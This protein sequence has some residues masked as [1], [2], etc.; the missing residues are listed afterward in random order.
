MEI[1][2]TYLVGYLWQLFLSAR[3]AYY[4][5]ANMYSMVALNPRPG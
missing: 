5:L 2:A 3:G 4:M 1:Y